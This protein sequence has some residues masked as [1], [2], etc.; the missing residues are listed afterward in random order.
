MTLGLKVNPWPRDGWFETQYFLVG[1]FPG[2]DN[3]SPISAPAL[4]YR[5]AHAIAVGLG[6]DLAGELYVGVVLQNLLVLISACFVY[7]TLRA[8]RFG[9]LAG[10]IAVAFLLCVLS[11]NLAQAFY[12]ESTVIFLMSAVMLIVAVVKEGSPRFWP[13]T[14]TCGVLVGLLVL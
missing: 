6:F 4:L 13:L 3:Y 10:T 2:H 1:H 7:F 11:T 5:L 9:A 8:L 14:L 12:S